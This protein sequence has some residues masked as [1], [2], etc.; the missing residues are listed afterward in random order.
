MRLEVSSF[1]LLVFWMIVGVIV[2]AIS[3]QSSDFL[4]RIL[5][6]TFGS[7]LIVLVLVFQY[8]LYRKGKNGELVGDISTSE[9]A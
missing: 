1:P 2:T 4:N 5:V 9:H 8:E 3:T 6:L 7:M